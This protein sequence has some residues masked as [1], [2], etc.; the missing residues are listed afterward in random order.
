MVD[1]PF[2]RTAT[3]RDIFPAPQRARSLDGALDL[4]GTSDVGTMFSVDS[5]SW[6]AAR[7]AAESAL[8]EAPLAWRDPQ[9]GPVTMIRAR[10]SAVAP[11]ALRIRRSP[12]RHGVEW[13]RLRITPTYVAIMAADVAGV[14]HACRSLRQ[15]CTAEARHISAMEVEDWPDFAARGVMLDISRDRIPTAAMLA[16]YVDLFA[17]WKF[18]QLQLYTE[19]TFAYAGHEPVWRGTS[20]MTAAEVRAL[21]ALCRSRGIELVPNQNSLGHMEHWLRHGPYRSLAETTGAWRTPWGET[22]RTPTTL[23]PIDPGATRLIAD[24]YS[25]LLPNFTSR[26]LNVGCDEPFELGQGR[27]A[28]ACARLGQGRVYLDYIRKLHRLLKSHDRRMQFWAD[29]ILKYPERVRELPR[30]TTPLIWGYEAAHPFDVECR[31]VRDAGLP[32]YVCPGTS[33]WCSFSGRTENMR[34]NIG[35]AATQG[36]QYG[37]QGLL[38]TDWGDYG[39]RQQA[40]VSMAGFVLSA[41]L[42][43]SGRRNP[44]PDLPAVLDRHA[45][46]VRT[47]GAG[48]LWLEA[49]RVH[50]KSRIAIHNRSVFFEL[51]NRPMDRIASIDGLSASRLT[52]MAQSVARL[53][54]QAAGV[55]FG[56]ALLRD[57]FD[58]MLKIMSYACQRGLTALGA[59]RPARSR[60]KRDEMGDALAEIME[61]HRATWLARSR[62]GGLGRSMGHY[63]RLAKRKGG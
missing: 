1:F 3:V 54:E 22:R 57:E 15:L 36:R 51:L 30:N 23:C 25:Q 13:Y 34:A 29:W 31:R 40:P 44:D 46:G 50:E 6:R 49:G 38:I 16:G 17:S 12:S 21:D 8:K 19:H 61:R 53:A 45:F 18:N 35:S 41:A 14:R 60:R 28:Q 24:L 33:S 7:V 27:S 10:D 2:M 39:H 4:R 52:A 42:G 5:G 48:A 20:A 55:D 58:L 59:T 26:T 43:W 37:A 63:R 62:R 56:G 11:I 47:G 9:A 32:F